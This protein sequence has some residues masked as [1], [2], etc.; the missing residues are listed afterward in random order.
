MGAGIRTV[1]DVE[2]FFQAFNAG[3]YETLFA[4]YMAED[5][6]WSASEKVLEG[7]HEMLDYWTKSHSPI[8]ETL[9]RPENVVFGEGRVYLQVEIRL[10]FREDGSF[11]GRPY[12]KSEV[13]TMRCADYYELNGE[14]KIRRGVVYQRSLG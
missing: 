4:K 9:G 14:N 3:D 13:A 11:C 12:K 6:S 10:E 7:R 5:C 8:R 1:A 2:A